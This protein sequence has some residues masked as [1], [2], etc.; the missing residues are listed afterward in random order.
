[1]RRRGLGRIGWLL[2]SLALL[3]CPTAAD[4]DS[5]AG[6][7][8]TA[9]DLNEVVLDECVLDPTCDYVFGTA[10]RGASRL[11]PENTL[12]AIEK[13]IEMGF[14]V[15]EVDVRATA[16]DVL[17]L[18]HDSTVDRTT[19]GSGDVDEMTWAEIQ[20]L[21]IPSDFPDVPDQTVPTFAEALA[22]MSG[23]ALVDVDAKTGRMD[24]VADVIAEAGMER[25]CN[26]QV[27]SL[28]EAQYLRDEDPTIPLAPNAADAAEVASY[29]SVAPEQF[30]FPWQLDDAAVIASAHDAGARANQNALGASDAAAAVHAANGDDPCQA[31]RPIWERGVSVIQTDAPELLGPCLQALNAE[32]GWQHTV[33]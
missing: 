10:H 18:M 33:E 5:A 11:A 13:A 15:V 2:G 3:G 26:V 20:Q 31:Y 1:M 4:D 29:A 23:R 27:G 22:V 32:H 21:T 14:E 17:I 30:E 19:D 6:D 24:L 8:D 7:D 12:P 25:W 9:D 28:A 16:D